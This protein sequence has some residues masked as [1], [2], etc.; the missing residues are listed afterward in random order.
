MSSRKENSYTAIVSLFGAAA[1]AT[2]ATLAGLHR[3]RIGIIELLFLFAPLVIVPLGLELAHELEVLPEAPHPLLLRGFQ[4]F[5]AIAVCGSLC[6]PPGRS[7][8]IL[9]LFWWVACLLLGFSRLIKHPRARY[10]LLFF[11]LDVAHV[12]L[13][14]GA[15]WFVV[16]RAGW[17]PMGFQEPIILLTAIHFH[18]SGFATA[19]IAS[20]TLGFA[21]SRVSRGTSLRMLVLLTLS[22]PFA[23]AAGFVFSPLLRLVAAMTLAIVI[24]A[25]AGVLFGY[26][27]EFRSTAS[28]IYLRSAACAA[29]AAFSLAAL[30]AAGDYFHKGWITV[31]GMANSHGVLNALGFVLLGLLGWLI[32]LHAVDTS[33][34]QDGRLL[35][36]VYAQSRER[37]QTVHPAMLPEFVA[38]DLYDR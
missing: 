2:L 3:V 34:E 8:A 13:V 37:R 22:L 26:A 5:A 21:R 19:V 18:Y 1:W 36:G 15:S 27:R 7:A 33:N 29:F 14:L 9:S 25:L 4:L 32:E 12:D 6:I 20:A 28:R 10:S 24:T 23:L 11:A 35:I 30:Y 17:R 31:P 38:R 16:S